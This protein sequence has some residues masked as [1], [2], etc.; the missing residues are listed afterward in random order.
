MTFTSW[1]DL[2]LAL[3]AIHL[4]LSLSLSLFYQSVYPSIH[5]SIR[6]SIRRPIYLSVCLSVYLS[7][8]LSTYLSS[9]LSIY[10]SI[11]LSIYPSIHLSIYPS[12][13]PSIHLSIYPSIHLSIY[14]SIYL[15][16]S[17]SIYLSVCLSICLSIYLSIHPSIYP[18]FSLSVPST[19]AL[20]LFNDQ[21]FSGSTHNLLVYF[22]ST[23]LSSYSTCF[24]TP[25]ISTLHLFTSP[26]LSLCPYRLSLSTRLSTRLPPIIVNQDHISLQ[27]VPKTS[28]NH[29]L[30]LQ[31]GARSSRG[32][33]RP[34]N[35]SLRSQT[36]TSQLVQ[37]AFVK[38]PP[39]PLWRWRRA[40]WGETATLNAQSHL[41]I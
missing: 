34:P 38:N 22:S 27:N 35:L 4:S 17:L 19:A 6:L 2:T 3:V 5:P 14:P 13:H 8:H 16:I 21:L 32:P 1:Y 15:S 23:R 41:L 12:I 28:P 10:P 31:K 39:T 30:R 25:S 29:Q 20:Q 9:Y 26:G 18:C 36:T 7:T 40:Y 24:S 11:H 33:P 37:L